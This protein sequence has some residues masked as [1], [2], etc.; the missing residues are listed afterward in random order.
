MGK[1]CGDSDLEMEVS[2]PSEFRKIKLLR[3]TV[4]FIKNIDNISLFT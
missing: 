1:N 2:T 4:H 3:V